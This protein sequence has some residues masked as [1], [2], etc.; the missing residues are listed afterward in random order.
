MLKTKNWNYR[1]N[2]SGDVGRLSDGV[3]C[4]VD[5]DEVQH[6][7]SEQNNFLTLIRHI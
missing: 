1:I 2:I 6:Y 4:L 5:P 7:F 3:S